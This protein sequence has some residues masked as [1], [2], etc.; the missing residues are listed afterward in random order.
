MSRCR[1]EITIKR[2]AEFEKRLRIFLE[3]A[4]FED[5]FWIWEIV[6]FKLVVQT[7]AWAA[8]V[9]NPRF[10]AD[11]RAGEDHRPAAFIEQRL[12]L[13]QFDVQIC[14]RKIIRSGCQNGQLT[15]HF[16]EL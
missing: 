9:G 1:L 14:H 15:A 3:E 8:E 13:F 5:C 2:L 11:T 7:A 6:F 4:Y 10:R 16:L 12:K